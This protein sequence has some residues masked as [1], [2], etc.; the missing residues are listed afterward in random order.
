[1]NDVRFRV[2]PDLRLDTLLLF[3]QHAAHF[4]V[5]NSREHGALHDCTALVVLNVAHPDLA[6]ESDFLCK[7]LFLEVA[8]R[9]IVGVCQ[10]MHHIAGSLDI[11]FEMGHE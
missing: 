8:N 3:Q 6:I 4:E 7:T 10:E 11:V 1:M 2:S 9:I 5:A